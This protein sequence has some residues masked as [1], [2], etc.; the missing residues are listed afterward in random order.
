MDEPPFGQPAAAERAKHSLAPRSVQRHEPAEKHGWFSDTE[1]EDAPGYSP[2]YPWTPCLQLDGWCPTIG[3]WFATKEECDR[4][5]KDNLLGQRLYDAPDPEPPSDG[6]FTR[7]QLEVFLAGVLLAQMEQGRI[8]IPHD[9][10]RDAE[11]AADGLR[12]AQLCKSDGTIV[13][14]FK[15]RWPVP[16]RE[17][18]EPD[19]GIVKPC[20]L[21]RHTELDHR[22]RP[23][24]Y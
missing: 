1:A 17:Y 7:P 5:I 16:C 12:L 13:I 3:V 14:T 6:V 24:R 18:Q 10:I 9:A 8:E 11:A 20:V 19:D 4:F 23:L 2:A 15:D 22:D 21:C